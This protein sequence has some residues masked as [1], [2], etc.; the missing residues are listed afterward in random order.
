MEEKYHQQYPYDILLTP[1][2]LHY[3]GQ[4]GAEIHSGCENPVAVLLQT[5]ESLW[6]LCTAFQF[7]QELVSQASSSQIR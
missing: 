2:A 5:K 1:P 4:P 3:I 7:L 6:H